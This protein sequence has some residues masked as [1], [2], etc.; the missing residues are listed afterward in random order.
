MAEPGTERGKHA[1]SAAF[2]TALLGLTASITNK[3]QTKFEDEND[4]LRC[5]HA[6]R[7]TPNA[8]RKPD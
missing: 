4:V 2:Q 6:K 7:Q 1:G 5:R 8:E 3:P